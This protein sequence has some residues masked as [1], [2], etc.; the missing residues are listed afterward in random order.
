[1][2]AGELF[3]VLIRINNAEGGDSRVSARIII[4]F[5]EIRS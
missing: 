5:Q 2:I 4:G 1:M 3:H